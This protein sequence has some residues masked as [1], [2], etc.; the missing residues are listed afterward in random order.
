MQRTY[1]LSEIAPTRAEGAIAALLTQAGRRQH[2]AAGA[3]IQQRG[4]AGGGFWLIEQG[5]VSVCRFG[6]EGDITVFGIMGAGDLFGE[7]A[8][9]AGVPRQVDAVADKDVVLVRIDAALIDRLLDTEPNFARWLLKSLGNQLRAALDQIDRDRSL[10][11]RA[12][13]GLLL[14]DLARRDG[15]AIAIT[16]QGLGEL[17]G[18][19]RVTVGQVLG[20]LARAGL[21][22][23]GYRQI[24]LRDAAQL[25]KVIA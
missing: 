9:F 1:Q 5:T 18:L 7:M 21:V 25:G 2:F 12:R 13:I 23:L 20:E 22:E 11:A 24:I 16:Q 17:L 10:S 15:P 6:G 14:L 4:D 8:H 3:L 19:S